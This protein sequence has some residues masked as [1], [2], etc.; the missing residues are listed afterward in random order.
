M[1]L[2]GTG[3]AQDGGA[4]DD[5]ALDSTGHALNGGAD[6]AD[7]GLAGTSH[8]LDGEALGD[9]KALDST[10]RAQGDEALGDEAMGDEALGDGVAVGVEGHH[11]EGPLRQGQ[12]VPNLGRGKESRHVATLLHEPPQRNRGFPWERP[13]KSKPY[14]RTQGSLS[15]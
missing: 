8:A 5:K 6:Y 15:W 9:D 14:N 2:D 7:T 12:Y 3:D 11:G 4:Y 13:W 1:A 10:G